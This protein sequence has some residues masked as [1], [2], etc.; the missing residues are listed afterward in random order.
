[1]DNEYVVV[2]NMIELMADNFDFNNGQD[3]KDFE[4]YVKLVLE[5]YC[6][7]MAYDMDVLEEYYES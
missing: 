7:D 5:D 4:R 2:N 6:H 3:I 1:M